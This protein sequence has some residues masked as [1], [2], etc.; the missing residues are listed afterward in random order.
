MHARCAPIH[1]TQAP[2]RKLRLNAAL[3]VKVAMN[4]GQGNPMKN[5]RVVVLSIGF[6]LVFLGAYLGYVYLAP[7]FFSAL[8]IS[9]DTPVNQMGS[10]LI[11]VM[12]VPPLAILLGIGIGW[13]FLPLACRALVTP[14]SFWNWMNTEKSVNIPVYSSLFTLIASKVFGPSGN[15]N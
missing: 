3:C 12:L 4:L 8:G 6:V 5:T 2:P 13:L 7:L 1:S 15:S 14:V 11:F 9:P 10:K